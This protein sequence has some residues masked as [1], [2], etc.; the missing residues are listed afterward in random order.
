MGALMQTFETPTPIAATIDL[1]LGDL[2]IVA[3]DRGT[4]TVEIK[5]TDGSNKED[6]KAAEATRVEYDDGRLLVKAPKVRSWLNRTGGGSLD[7]TIELPTGSQLHAALVSA[8]ARC[9]GQLGHCRIT[10]GLGHLEI[11]EATTLD[12]KS[13]T[14]DIT[15][16]RAIG[17]AEIRTGSG[18][19]RVR[20]LDVSGVIKNTNGDT[21]VGEAGGDLRAQAANGDIAVDRAH[22]NVVAKSSNGDVRLGAAERGT[23]VLETQLG[24]VEIGIPEGTAAYLDVSTSA[25]KVHNT[26][27]PAEA[28]ESRTDTVR[29]RA[30]TALGEIV[31]RRP[32]EAVT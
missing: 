31:I 5:P 8:D 20:E 13:G 2:R 27:D 11:D 10:T 32:R 9:H 18:E 22:D 1:G 4:T 12:I 16:Q 15:V 17:H 29:V 26:L 30:R 24:D 23:V 14:G 7:V 25:G 28:P 19:V 21:W 6:V 3:G